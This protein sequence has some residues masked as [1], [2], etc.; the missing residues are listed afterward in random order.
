M[1][2]KARLKAPMN[3]GSLYQGTTLFKSLKAPMP[4]R[5]R[6]VGWKEGTSC[7]SCA[8]FCLVPLEAW[9]PFVGLFV[10]AIATEP[11]DQDPGKPG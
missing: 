4:T 10:E 5:S 6:K 1:R 9:S 11:K 3:P 7:S 2:R 8:G